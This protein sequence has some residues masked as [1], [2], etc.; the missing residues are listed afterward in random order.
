MN[1]P[2]K[3]VARRIIQAVGGSGIPPEYGLQYFTA[4]IDAFLDPL[5]AEYLSSFIKDGGSSFKLVVGA[6]GGGKT[7]FLYCVRDRAWQHEFAVSYVRLS[8]N[9]TPFF[10]LE[11]VYQ[12][13]AANLTYP[14]N[15][16]QLLQGHQ[17]GVEAFI[18]A[19]YSRKQ[20][21]LEHNGCPTDQIPQELRAH[22]SYLPNFES[23]SF[24]N[25]VKQAFTSLTEDRKADFAAI[26]QWLK[27]EGFDGRKATG[28]PKYGILQKIDRTTA[29]S[30]I[31]SLIQWV[32]AIGYSGLVV[33]FDEAETTPSMSG[34][35]KDLL[36]SNLR[37]LVDECGQG[38]MSH[39]LFLYAVPDETF[40]AGRTHI[41]EALRQRLS[42]AFDEL[43]P[44][45]AKIALEKL[46]V[47]PID[48]LTEI[49]H[50]LAHVYEIAFDLRFDPDTLSVLVRHV[51]EAAYKRR[52]SDIGYKRLFVQSVVKAFNRLRKSPT[53]PLSPEDAELLIGP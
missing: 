15:Q 43:D 5:E 19:W 32:R 12:A 14:L 18:R 23:I 21:E 1:L 51:A 36:L 40:L 35:E 49:G 52:Y 24:T 33:L 29:F 17:K 42:T 45:G 47:D 34:K 50:K 46:S 10:K 9:E 25:A 37:E 3:E 2:S 27:G 13:I 31:R 53:M 41:Y 44:V 8:P 30:M 4:G 48:L 11:A 22:L 20:A 6:Y 28:H 26:L 39:A 16:E 7:H 38:T